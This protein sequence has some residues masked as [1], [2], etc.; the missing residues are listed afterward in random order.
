MPEGPDEEHKLLARAFDRA[1]MAIV[2]KGSAD[3]ATGTVKWF[4]S[5][6]GYGFIQPD[7]GTKDVSSISRPS[8]GQA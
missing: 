7:G 6:K 1:R 2:S 3:V 5:T 4:N 8:R